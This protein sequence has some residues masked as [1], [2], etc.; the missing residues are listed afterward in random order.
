MRPSE[1]TVIS[2]PD[3]LI[4][5]D[6]NRP[7]QRIRLGHSQTF[8]RQFKAAPHVYFIF[9]RNQRWSIIAIFE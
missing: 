7:N 5:V 6:D 3:D 1:F 2:L 4:I 9:L 8:T